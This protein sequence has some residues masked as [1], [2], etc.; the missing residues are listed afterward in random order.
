MDTQDQAAPLVSV[1][2]VASASPYHE[3]DIAGFVEAEA[4]AYVDNGKAVYTVA[5]QATEGELAQ[6]GDELQ[7]DAAQADV[8]VDD[9]VPAAQDEALADEAAA[10][11]ELA[12]LPAEP[13]AEAEAQPAPEPAEAAPAAKP[14]P[15]RRK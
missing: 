8:T 4:K 7:L 2:F 1:T 6:A 5:E 10:Q 11:A 12:V 9:P 14:A 13:A 15:A 3:G